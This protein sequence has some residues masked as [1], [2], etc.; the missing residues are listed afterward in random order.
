[1]S[2]SLFDQDRLDP[3]QGAWHFEQILQD[4]GLWPVAGVDEVGRGC[5]AGP[6][7]AA[8]VILPKDLTEH[9]I[10]DSKRLSATQREPLAEFIKEVA[11]SVSVA[12]VEPMEID[13]INILQASLLAM[14]LAVKSLSVQPRAILVDGN[15]QVPI[16]IPQKTLIKGDSRSCSIAAASIVAK[17]YRD[18]LME[19]YGLEF[20]QYLFEKHKGY[21]TKSHR[22]MIRRF[23]PCPIHRKSFRGV[24]GDG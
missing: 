18:R 17:V 11:V 1:M 20:P 8:A 21:A 19:E 9:G 5:L 12:R 13:R 24:C 23:G 14:K 7:V 4:Q 10:T 2:R 6:V 3:V 15:Q 16:D 22:E